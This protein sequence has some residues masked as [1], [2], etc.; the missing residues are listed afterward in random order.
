VMLWW[1]GCTS[2]GTR[3]ATQQRSSAHLLPK[4]RKLVLE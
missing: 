4:T 2:A 1:A 3:W